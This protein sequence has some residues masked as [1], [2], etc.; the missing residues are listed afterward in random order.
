[1]FNFTYRLLNKLLSKR[2]GHIQSDRLFLTVNPSWNKNNSTAWYKNSPVGINEISK[3][4]KESATKIGLD[5]KNIK[6]TNHSYRSTA[7]SQL[8]KAGV[9]E[10]QLI[11]ITGHGS[12][13]S[14]KPYLQLDAEHH[15]KIVQQM[16]VEAGA[17]SSTAPGKENQNYNVYYN[18]NFS[19][20]NFQC[21]DK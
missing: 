21:S 14:I 17:S 15:T 18:C 2:G 8:A 10:Q 19:C 9:Q 11:K 6:I 16:R 1:M 5:V 7:V 12:V 13:T 4:M 20:S 3:W